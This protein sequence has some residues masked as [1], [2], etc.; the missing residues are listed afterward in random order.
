MHIPVMKRV[1]S[2]HIDKMGYDHDR[3]EFHVHFKDGTRVK[4]LAVPL[5]VADM[6]RNAAS[7]G[8]ALLS[9]VK[10]TFRYLHY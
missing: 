1:Q 7:P 9:H 6:V 4:Y 3:F 8:R 10:E 5:T 2:S